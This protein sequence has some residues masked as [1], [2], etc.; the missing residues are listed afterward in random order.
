MFLKSEF[1]VKKQCVI[2]VCCTGE[3]NKQNLIMS[4]FSARGK[5]KKKVSEKKSRNYLN[6]RL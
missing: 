5:K 6:H 4:G 1:M 3:K 2:L